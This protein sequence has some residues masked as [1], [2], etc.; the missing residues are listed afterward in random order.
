MTGSAYFSDGGG[1]VENMLVLTRRAGERIF[2]GK[3]IVVTIV[4]FA[5]GK[6]RVGIDAGKDVPIY[7]EEVWNRIQAN[8]NKQLGQFDDSVDVEG[9]PQN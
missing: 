8:R 6:V 5:A 1:S 4:D 9:P 2:I 3:D 7:R